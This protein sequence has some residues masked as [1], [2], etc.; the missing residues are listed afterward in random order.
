MKKTAPR[1]RPS[2]ILLWLTYVLVISGCAMGGQT[3]KPSVCPTLPPPPSNVMRRPSAEQSLR[4]LL[5]EPAAMPM[6]NSE[7]AKPSSSRTEPR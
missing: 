2:L 6:T 1:H 7:H 4:E 5:F 3:V